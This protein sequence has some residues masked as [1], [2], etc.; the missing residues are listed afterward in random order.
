[1]SA[2]LR[3]GDQLSRDPTGSL[4]TVRAEMPGRLRLVSLELRRNPACAQ[5]LQRV[6][7]HHPEVAFLRV[8]LR[9]GSF[10]LEHVELK[11]WS[12]RAVQALLDQ[13]DGLAAEPSPEPSNLPG[14]PLLRITLAGT[15]LLAQASV[16]PPL[17]W[18][19]A[20][21]V[22]P[23]LL[24]PLLRELPQAWSARRLP[25]E[26]LDL[27]WFTTLILRGELGTVAA[28]LAMENGSQ[29]LQ[30]PID[31]DK[32]SAA[33]L[34]KDIHRWLDQAC[35]RV[36]D[37]DA[38]TRPIGQL[39]RGDLIRLGA[40]EMVPLDGFIVS[41]GAVVS[42]HLLDGETALIDV[43]PFQALPLGV[44]LVQGELV[45]K[46]NQQFSEQ[47]IYAELLAL[48][49]QD[50]IPWGVEHARR[51]H[52][53]LMPFLLGGGL[54]S[55]L[56][57]Y[58]HQAASLMQFDPINDWQLSASVAYRGA[59][60]IFNGWGV[61]L[62][63]GA[64]LD[65]LSACRTLV[66]SEGA[67]CFGIQ[68]QLLRVERLDG[69]YSSDALVEIIAGF[70]RFMDPAT[71]ALFPLQGLMLERDLE[72][73]LIQG[74]RP[75]GRCGLCGELHGKKVWLGGG[76]LLKSLGIKRP[77]EM[78]QQRG[79]HWTFVLVNYQVVGG[80]LY[81]DQLKPTVARSLKR[82]RQSGWSLHLVSTWHGDTLDAIARELHL[83]PEAIHPSMDLGQ[84]TAL[85]R[86]FDRSSGPI[87]YLGSTLMDSGAFAEADISLA[88]SDG[89]LSLPADMADIVLPA[90]R[91][92]RLVDCVAVAED[93]GSNNGLNFYLT[94]LPHSSA[95]LLS[96]LLQLDPLLAV[97]LADM[98]MLMVEVNNLMT[99]N[100]LRS[101]HHLGW[102]AQR[103][104][105][106]RRRPWT[107]APQGA[108]PR[109]AL[110][111]G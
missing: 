92:D 95:L 32:H 88:V 8:N 29:I 108:R 1:M 52:H 58:P 37:G 75:A 98:P 40:G 79:L 63:H 74:I 42:K 111:K 62:R 82:L 77:P 48:N 57:G 67:I 84:R 104:R 5:A 68:R 11:H 20:I 21:A 13:L 97:L 9:A 83:P 69:D 66:I 90:Q 51:V 94:L 18:L 91:L 61:R 99:Y 49:P 72:P 81:R 4:W 89:S 71:I 3:P 100:H 107:L 28:E 45:F 25:E 23:S 30:V 27:A 70:R 43:G 39:Q 46:L 85:I 59:Q 22:L 96:F 93:I 16:G 35:Y 102:K 86:D 54:V 26:S 24:W 31:Q 2:R 110:G 17:L 41:G 65:R 12:R 10:V 60:N 47:P 36:V 73:S 7:A 64:V 109:Q 6:A 105:T 76:Q 33:I 80:L 101:H 19:G 34:A 78:P 50:R 103:K 106:S 53:Q 14:G 55:L 56:L 44:F 87:A 15:L 38:A